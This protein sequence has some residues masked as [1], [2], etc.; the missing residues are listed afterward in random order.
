MPLAP[1]HQR[2]WREWYQLERWRRIRRHQ[3]RKTP[4]CEMC[5]KLGRLERATIADHIIE[6]EGDWN[7]FWTGALQSLCAPCHNSR[8]R[9]VNE[10]GYDPEIGEDG[11]PLDRN[12]PVYR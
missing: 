11:W 7:L 6:H 1:N 5:L 2:P 10:R 4:L 12:H 3:L 9:L 8:K